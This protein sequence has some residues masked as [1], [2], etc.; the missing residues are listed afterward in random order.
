MANV[1]NVRTFNSDPI[2]SS[3]Y[4]YNSYTGNSSIT[5]NTILIANNPTCLILQKSGTSILFRMSG[6][7]TSILLGQ[8]LLLEVLQ[9]QEQVLRFHMLPIIQTIVGQIIQIPLVQTLGEKLKFQW[10]ELFP[11]DTESK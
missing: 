9:K 5:S 1:F 3:T 8:A 7:Q 10:R 4:G 2:S 6:N 11:G